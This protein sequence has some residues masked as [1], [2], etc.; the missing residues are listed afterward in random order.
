MKSASPNS[1]DIRILET[2]VSPKS[3]KF[4]PPV[5]R[6]VLSLRFSPEQEEEVHSLLD[7]NNAGTITPDELEELESY[8]RVGNLLSLLK[9]KARAAL[10]R[11]AA[12]K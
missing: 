10:P 5:A 12:K 1:R 11:S 4:S 7:K 8:V 6:A 9:A 2:V 3:R